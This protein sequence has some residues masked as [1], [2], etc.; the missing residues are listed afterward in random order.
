MFLTQEDN[1]A[2]ILITD[3]GIGIEGKNLKTIF[4]KLSQFNT[5]ITRD[6][7]EGGLG[8]AVCKGLIE[9]HNGKIWAE[10]GGDGLGTE[11]HISLP[12]TTEIHG[13]IRK[14]T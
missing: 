9:G 14:V 10:S 6:Y 1:D 5:T 12:L 11:I 8:L 2:K 7:Q 4:E 3:N 13:T